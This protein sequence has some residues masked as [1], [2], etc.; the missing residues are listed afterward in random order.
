MSIFI[1]DCRIWPEHCSYIFEFWFSFHLWIW[2]TNGEVLNLT[3]RL[4]FLFAIWLSILC[5]PHNS[6]THGP[7]RK[8]GVWFI[9]FFFFTLAAVRFILIFTCSFGPLTR[10]VL[11]FLF[12]SWMWFK[13]HIRHLLHECSFTC[14]FVNVLYVQGKIMAWRTC[15]DQPCPYEYV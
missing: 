13:K 12:A 3:E 4:Y 11:F 5:Y 6:L 10:V 8:A 14:F 7:A 1:V 9:F 15:L 2:A